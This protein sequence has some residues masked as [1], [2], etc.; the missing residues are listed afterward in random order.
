[1]TILVDM[2]DTL[3][4]LIQAWISAVNKQH[5]RNVSYDDIVSWDMSAAFPGLSREQV[6][7]VPSQP[8][9]WKTVEPMPG[10]AEALQRLMAAGHEIYIVTATTCESVH[11]KMTELLFRYFPFLSW[12]QVIIT[13][14]KQ[15]IRGDVLIDDGVHNLEG[16]D[17]VKILM[18][19][20]H[21]RNYDAEANGMIRVHSWPEIENV[22]RDLEAE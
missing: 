8:G 20:P 21:N 9:F 5:G 10:A 13:E 15:M 4:Q 18:T 12:K 2:D 16:G 7:S 3:E 14:N 17:Y 19:A 22:L 11:E 6:Y 1:M